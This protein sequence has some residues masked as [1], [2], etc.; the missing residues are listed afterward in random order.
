MNKNQP[1]LNPSL[2]TALVSL[3]L[4]LESELTKYQNQ[5]Q[6]VLDTDNIVTDSAPL[7]VDF[8]EFLEDV[9]LKESSINDESPPNFKQEDSVPVAFRI[10]PTK[11]SFLDMLLTPWGMLAIILF[12]I[13][14]A[15]IFI[16][17]G[18]ETKTAETSSNQNNI[19]PELLSNRNKTPNNEQTLLNQ[20]S[21]KQNLLPSSETQTENSQNN[22]SPSSINQLPT[23]NNNSFIPSPPPPQSLTSL[24]NT[25]PSQTQVN[26]NQQSSPYP[27]LTTALL[28]NSAK[29]TGQIP[30][31]PPTPPSTNNS[32]PIANKLQYYVL[33]DYDNTESLKQIQ[34]VIPN[35]VLTYLDKEMKIQLAV[36]SQEEQ[37]KQFIQTHKENGISAYIYKAP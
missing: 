20:E 25:T 24:G 2:K 33:S 18:I 29:K 6:E 31:A 5:K 30:V 34:A 28:S 21:V 3:D 11:K 35:A 16:Y 19:S 36:F 23:T 7:S 1:L 14:N 8:V 22:V 26:G 10:L 9:P 32:Q 27:N 15:I 17:K 4:N 37:A 12:F 13:G